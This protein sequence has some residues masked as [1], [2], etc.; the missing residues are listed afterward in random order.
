MNF[1]FKIRKNDYACHE[2]EVEFIRDYIEKISNLNMFGLKYAQYFITNKENP[3]IVVQ[4]GVKRTAKLDEIY[5]VIQSVKFNNRFI[6][7]TT[8]KV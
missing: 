5:K 6:T 2:D 1:F 4:Y 7:Y 8:P 3:C